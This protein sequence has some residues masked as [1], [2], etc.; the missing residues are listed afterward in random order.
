[1]SEIKRVN[2][3][4]S[5]FSNKPREKQIEKAVRKWTEKGYRLTDTTEDKPGCLQQ[6]YSLGWARG[7]TR[8][9]FIK[10]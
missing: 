5:S 7:T 8:L 2:V 1:M 4:Y 6:I 3:K 9:T 10:D